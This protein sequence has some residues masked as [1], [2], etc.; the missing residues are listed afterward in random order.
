MELLPREIVPDA[1]RLAE[2]FSHAA[3]PAFLLAGVGGFTSLLLRG[4]F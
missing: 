3:A 1:A 2:I 4:E